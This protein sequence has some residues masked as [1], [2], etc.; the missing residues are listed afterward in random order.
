MNLICV[1]FAQG[2]YQNIKFGSAY[3]GNKKYSNNILNSFYIK[4]FDFYL[5]MLF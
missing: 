2:R 5:K 4:I 1:C 3:L